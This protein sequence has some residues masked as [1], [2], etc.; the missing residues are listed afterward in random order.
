VS[1]V[2]NLDAPPDVTTYLHRAGRTARAG[3]SGM[4]SN[5]FTSDEEERLR[6]LLAAAAAGLPDTLSQRRNAAQ[7]ARRMN[8]HGDGRGGWS[9]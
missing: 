8:G 9:R 3:G 4:V 6:A 1:H 7:K 5:I 2:V